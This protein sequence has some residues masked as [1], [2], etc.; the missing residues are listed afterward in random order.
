MSSRSHGANTK[1]LEKKYGVV[2]AMLYRKN[3]QLKCSYGIGIV[4]YENMLRAQHFKCAV[5]KRYPDITSSDSGRHILAV[6]HNHDTG[7]V[8]GLLCMDCNC[9]I[10]LLKDRVD[11]VRNLSTYLETNQ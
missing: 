1:R 3:S 11:V 7:K 8:R 6:D 10:G 2:G 4:E 5:C 9:A